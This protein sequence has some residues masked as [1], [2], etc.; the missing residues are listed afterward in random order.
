VPSANYR[1][2]RDAIQN[3]QQVTCSYRGRYRELCPH[4]VGTTGGAEKLLAYQFGGETNTTLPPGGEWRCL[5]IA[6]MRDVRARPG[7]WHEGSRHQSG[8]TCVQ[9]IDIDIN[10]HVR[11]K[12]PRLRLVYSAPHD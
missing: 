1:I 11:T 12:C 7:P 10:V 3:E 8:Q 4:I 9:D 2:I 5:N 6:D